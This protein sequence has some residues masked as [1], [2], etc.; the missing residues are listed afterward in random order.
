M[1]CMSHKLILLIMVGL[2]PVF[3][4]AQEGEA[5]PAVP[6]EKKEKPTQAIEYTQKETKLNTI[7]TRIQ[8]E[9]SDFD[10]L[11]WRKAHATD[12]KE[13]ESI[14]QEM[15]DVTNQR[16]KDVEE[17]N[18]VYQD[19][20]YRY[21]SK[22]V[23]LNRLYQM[24]QKRTVDE[25]QGAADLD[26]MLTRVKRVIEKKFAPFEPES[27]KTAKVAPAQPDEPPKKLRLEK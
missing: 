14:L 26:D 18:Q 4:N 21:P 20:Q 19:F 25:M 24:E 13:I 10:R 1:F 3:A 5:A 27:E 7:Q 23:E 9:Q 8:D 2:V 15:V 12:Q 11:V 22:N 17:Y 6:K 16:N